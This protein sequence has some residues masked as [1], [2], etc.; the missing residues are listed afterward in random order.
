MPQIVQR[1]VLPERLPGPREHAQRRMVGQLPERAPQR[2]PQRL[3]RSRQD[4][5]AHLLLIQPQPYE[6]VRRRR[7]LLHRPGSFA[8]DRD[9]LPSRIGIGSRS[10]Q[11]L[12][13]TGPGR[14]PERDQRP[15][16]V[17]AEPGEKLAELPIGDAARG[18]LRHPGP[19]QAGPAAGERI[20]RIA[21][22]PRTAGPAAGQ[23]ERIDHRPGP[24]IE[25]EIV[26]VTQHRLAVR[27]R[28]RRVTAVR[29]RFPGDQ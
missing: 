13:G 5:A 2:P 28:R 6:R 21:V 23:R 10:P 8:D 11:Q 17:R 24:G 27:R 12:R 15:V 18:P 7:K 25:V 20:H 1:P 3:V 9:Q 22:R 16:A 19:E 26:K 14:D 4:Q 29:S